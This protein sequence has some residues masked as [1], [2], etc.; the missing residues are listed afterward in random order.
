MHQNTVLIINFTEVDESISLITNLS[1]VSATRSI[2]D[3]SATDKWIQNG[4][5]VAGGNEEGMEFN[6]LSQPWGLYVDDNL[7]IYVADYWNHRIVEWK[8]GA[9][10]GH[11]VAGDNQEGE[12]ADQLNGPTDVIVDKAKDNLIISDRENGRVV[13]WPLRGGKGGKT[14]ISNVQCFGLTLDDHGFLYVSDKDKHEVRRWRIGE[15]HGIVVAGGNG[16]GDR[17]D[18]LNYPTYVFVDQDQSVYVSEYGNQRVTKWVKGAK[19]G[20]IVAGGHDQ[21]D[22][23]T[24]LSNPEGVVV[25]QLGTVY[26]AEWGNHRVTRWPKGATSGSVVV[27]GNDQG[28]GANQLYCPIGLSFDRHGNL[29]VVDLGN[30]RV[31]R[32][33]IDRSL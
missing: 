10:K 27:G 21:G 29:Y 5:T 26:V 18:Q 30:N 11:L 8:S 22:D 16:E 19:E 24:Q 3:I 23:L 1:F 32:F 7:T 12:R 4:V 17:L 13:L 2:P 25:D 15:T 28:K 31:Q 6:Q 20:I 14:I 33:N 9:T